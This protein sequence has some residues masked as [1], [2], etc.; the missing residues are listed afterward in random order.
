MS[1]KNITHAKTFFEEVFSFLK[2][3]LSKLRTSRANPSLV[4]DLFFD[5]YGSRVRIKEVAAITTPSLQTISIQ[6]WDKNAIEGIAGGEAR[7]DELNDAEQTYHR[8]CSAAEAQWGKL[9][10]SA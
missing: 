9:S 10:Q 7:S 6:P 2:E 4:E 1:Q 3:E 5:Y 8:I